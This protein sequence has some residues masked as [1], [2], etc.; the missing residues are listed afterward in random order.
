MIFLVNKNHIFQDQI[1]SKLMFESW[2]QQYI[3]QSNLNPD[4]QG[5]QINSVKIWYLGFRLIF[6]IGLKHVAIIN[7]YVSDYNFNFNRSE[8]YYHPIAWRWRFCYIF[9][10]IY[11]QG[12]MYYQ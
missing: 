2:P 6:K 3:L 12:F 11:I 4:Y 1:K 9:E 8:K 7:G 5:K 10:K